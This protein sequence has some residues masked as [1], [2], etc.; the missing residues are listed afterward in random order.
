VSTLLGVAA[1][2]AFVTGLAGGVH[3]AG[4]CGGIVHA[5]TAGR[6][7]SGRPST[8]YLLAYN[9]GRL[10][11]YA[12]A[13]ALAGALGQAG[14]LTRA[15]PLLQPVLAAVA[16]VSLIL[17]GAWL[18]GWL[19]GVARIEALGAHVWRRLQPL[20]RHLLPVTS[21]PRALALGALWG[22]LPCGMV[23]LV[24]LT[25]LAL[26]TAWEGALVMLAFGL[27]TLPNLLGL[28]L[29]WQRF[30]QRRRA[31][32]PRML[33]GALIAGFGCYGLVWSVQPPAIGT[34][35]LVCRPLPGL[36]GLQR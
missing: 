9:A 25:A 22:W 23:Y 7:T 2:A 27:G 21:L 10:V 6:G 29:L 4:M 30:L 15:A 26:G 16:S 8:P 31:A 11:S 20:T 36:A 17:L 32:L 18:A 3:C 19:P 34:D 35:G 24:L 12:C 1:G 13:G 33:A 28:G 5:F 14:L